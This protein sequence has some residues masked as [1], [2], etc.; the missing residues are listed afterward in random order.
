MT[1]NDKFSDVHIAVNVCQQRTFI[2]TVGK[3]EEPE[4][5]SAESRLG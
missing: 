4:V 2:Q 1:A 5:P 3:P